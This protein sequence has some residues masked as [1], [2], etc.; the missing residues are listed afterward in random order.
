MDPAESVVSVGKAEVQQIS[1]P[2]KYEQQEMDILHQEQ[3]QRVASASIVD[4][5]AT[6]LAI[7]E[8]PGVEAMQEIEEALQ[9]DET[10]S[11]APPSISDSSVSNATLEVDSSVSKP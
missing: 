5:G 11:I 6:D 10:E 9:L 3:N 1:A 8:A 4:Q 7:E 2:S